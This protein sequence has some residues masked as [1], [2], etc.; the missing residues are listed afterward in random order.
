[1]TRTLSLLLLSLAC[2]TARAQDWT[3][4]PLGTSADLYAVQNTYLTRHWV[5]GAQ[6]FAGWSNDD[7]SSWTFVQTGVDTQLFSVQEP[8][9]NA[10]YFGVEHVLT[11][12]RSPWQNPFVERVIGSI[13]RECLDHTIILNEG[14]LQRVLKGYFAYYH[15]FRTH[16]GLEKE[17][18]VPRQVEPPALG[19]VTAEPMVGGLHHRCFRRAA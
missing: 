19:L 16:L 11:S 6:G 7:R 17:C 8:T 18:P 15:G 3:T 10:V 14:H 4:I 1:M 2:A 9:G 5:V 13:R 12:A